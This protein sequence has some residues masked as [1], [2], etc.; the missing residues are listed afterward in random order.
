MMTKATMILFG[1]FVFFFMFHTI[2][3]LDQYIPFK[4][5]EDDEE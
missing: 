4:V 3:Q 5:P 2:R 1:L